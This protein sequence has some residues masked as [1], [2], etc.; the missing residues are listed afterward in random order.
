MADD[1]DEAQGNLQPNP[2]SINKSTDAYGNLPR[3]LTPEELA[4]SGTQKLILNDLS[5]AE[6]KVQELAPYLDKYYNVFTQ[7]SVLD[8]KLKKS[9]RAEVLYS[10]SM[11]IGGLIFGLGKIFL[12]KDGVLAAFMFGIG[13]LLIIGGLA[14]KFLFPK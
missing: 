9:A 6:A 7:K 3:G 13:G 11:T 14:F 12:D 10:F 2:N 4:Q 8:E 1:S 5:K